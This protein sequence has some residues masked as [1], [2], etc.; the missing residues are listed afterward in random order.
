MI[1]HNYH[2]NK[3]KIAHFFNKIK[4]IQKKAD[5]RNQPHNYTTN[6]FP[7]DNEEYYNQNHQRFYS[8][9]TPGSY[10]IDQPDISEPYT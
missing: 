1:N 5:T 4:N 7:S 10:S 6:Y 3:T 8:S 2:K 9:Q